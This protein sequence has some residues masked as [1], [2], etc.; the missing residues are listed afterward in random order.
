M[1]VMIAS[2]SSS[3][4]TR[5]DL[6]TTTPLIETMATSVVPPPMSTTMLPVASPT[7]SPAPIAAAIGSS[8]MCTLRAP[9]SYAASLTARCSIEVVPL[10]TATT[11]RGLARNLLGCAFWMNMRNIR[12]A[13]SR[14]AI[15]PSLSGLIVAMCGGV[16]PI[17]R[18]A[19]LPTA[20]TVFLCRLIAMTEGSFST[21][22]FLRT[23]TSVLA[24]PRSTAM[25]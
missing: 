13:A 17:M 21:M 22:P 6:A 16:R 19:G 2:S 12:S 7:F 23:Y 9:A 1:W 8:M 18:L 5:S 15:T 11:M 14:S 25:S 20:T 4:P 24:V 10:G 3:P